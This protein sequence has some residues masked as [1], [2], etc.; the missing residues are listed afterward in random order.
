[1]VSLKTVG[2]QPKSSPLRVTFTG[3]GIIVSFHGDQGKGPQEVFSAAQWDAIV[4]DFKRGAY[5]RP[6]QE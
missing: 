2:L 1:M 6:V 3:N 5:D 4:E